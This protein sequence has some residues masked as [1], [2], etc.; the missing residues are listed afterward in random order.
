MYLLCKYVCKICRSYILRAS[1]CQ[2]PLGFSEHICFQN[3]FENPARSLPRWW[4][5]RV[6]P[7]WPQ[8]LQRLINHQCTSLAVKLGKCLGLG[9]GQHQGFKSSICPISI[10]KFWCSKFSGS[11]LWLLLQMLGSARALES[12]PVE[13]ARES[14]VA[15]VLSMS[16]LSMQSMDQRGMWQGMGDRAE[17]GPKKAAPFVQIHL[18]KPRIGSVLMCCDQLNGDFQL[19]FPTWS[20]LVTDEPEY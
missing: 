17:M 16:P 3:A 15:R 8:E 19:G 11:G 6:I 13:E 12:I 18:M 14:P 2:M 7:G 5:T 20:L 10:S 9:T 1:R 4:N